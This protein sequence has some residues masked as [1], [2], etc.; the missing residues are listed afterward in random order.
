MK[1]QADFGLCSQS[2]CKNLSMQTALSV[3]PG[4]PPEEDEVADKEL[5][6]Y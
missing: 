1:H 6:G 3:H 2:C 4:G 5:K